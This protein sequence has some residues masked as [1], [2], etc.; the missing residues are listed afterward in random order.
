[1][2]VQWVIRA[3]VCVRWIL[4]M[5]PGWA[6]CVQNGMTLENFAEVPHASIWLN[7]KN[8]SNNDISYWMGIKWTRMQ[9]TEAPIYDRGGRSPQDH[10]KGHLEATAGLQTCRSTGLAG[11]EFESS[12][13]TL[14]RW[15]WQNTQCMWVYW[16][17]TYTFGGE[18]IDMAMIS[19]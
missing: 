1:M 9:E 13:R 8:G 11:R 2:C 5:R 3:Q 19:T 16:E 15:S 10:G 14:I 4:H 6:I 17:E 12:G 7:C 18:F